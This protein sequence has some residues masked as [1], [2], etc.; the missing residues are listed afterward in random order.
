MLSDGD[1]ELLAGDEESFLID[2]DL[3]EATVDNDDDD[4]DDGGSSAVPHDPRRSRCPFWPGDVC[5]TSG[6]L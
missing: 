6:P 4:D 2:D 5:G 3:S 1:N